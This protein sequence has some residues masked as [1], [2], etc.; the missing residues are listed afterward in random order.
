M[1]KLC[2]ANQSVLCFSGRLSQ[3]KA[4]KG[5]IEILIEESIIHKVPIAIHNV[6]E[7]GITINAPADKIAPTK[8][9]GRLLPSFVQ[10]LSEK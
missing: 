6:G 2:I 10:V 3:T 8:K 1:K 7:L 9:Y 5:S 4:R